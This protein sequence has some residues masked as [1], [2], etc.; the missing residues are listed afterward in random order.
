M[1]P[2]NKKI[3]GIVFFLAAEVAV[4]CRVEDADCRRFGPRFLRGRQASLSRRVFS[5]NPM[6]E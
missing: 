3:L 5:N 2:Q 1:W 4:P 6:V